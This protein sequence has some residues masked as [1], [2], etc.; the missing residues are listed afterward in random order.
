MYYHNDVSEKV[1]L[2]MVM[3]TAD[4]MCSALGLTF[5][6]SW[7]AC[8]TELPEFPWINIYL[9]SLELEERLMKMLRVQFNTPFTMAP[10]I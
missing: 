10:M 3:K 2:G 6:H 7:K 1:K 8:L 4:S 5:G 9:T